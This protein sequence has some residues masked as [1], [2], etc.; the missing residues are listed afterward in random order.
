[1]RLIEEQRP[2]LGVIFCRTKRRAKAL[3]EALQELGYV[4]DELHGDL[5]QAKREQ[6]MKRFRDAKLQLLVATDVAARGLDVEGVTHVFNY[7]VPQDV[8]SYIHRIGRTARAGGEG[9]AITLV[10]PSERPEMAAIEQGI[11]QKL[12]RERGSASGVSLHGD[13]AEVRPDRQG[14]GRSGGRRNDRD[15]R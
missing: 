6:V 1:V 11:N 14:A 15:S 7:D 3:N 13:S 2:Y 10:V 12:E 5:S 9:L 4:S 8:D